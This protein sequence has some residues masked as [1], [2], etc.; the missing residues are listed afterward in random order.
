METDAKE[1]R[2][3]RRTHRWLSLALVLLLTL[4]ALPQIALAEDQNLKGAVKTVRVGSLISTLSSARTGP[5]CS[6]S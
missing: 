1:V 5:I 2:T 4:T 6:A 3:M